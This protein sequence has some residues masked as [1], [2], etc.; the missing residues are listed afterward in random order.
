MALSHAGSHPYPMLASRTGRP[1]SALSAHSNPALVASRQE[2]VRASM[3]NS[4]AVLA[5]TGTN[6]RGS[7]VAI[8][9]RHKGGWRGGEGGNHAV[10]LPRSCISRTNP[11]RIADLDEAGAD[12]PHGHVYRVAGALTISRA[13]TTQREIEA[14]PD[15]LTIDLS[16]I[17]RMDT[18]GAWIVYRTVR[19]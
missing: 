14:M 11:L 6:S 15:P 13:A 7:S 9:R 2:R 17:Q 10:H 12:E 3:P 18:V 16:Q 4:R 8:A 5:P 1:A 19:D